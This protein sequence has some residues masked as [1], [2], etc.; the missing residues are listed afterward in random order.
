MVSDPSASAVLG[1]DPADGENANDRHNWDD[2][3]DFNGHSNTNNF[4]DQ[5]N[6]GF[7][8]TGYGRSVQVDYIASSAN[9]ID[10]N[11]PAPAGGA[12]DTKRIIVTVTAPNGETFNL[13]AVVCNF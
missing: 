6:N 11:N 1:R 10:H 2:V 8:L 12:T 7:S 3:D 4:L 5:N 13:V 9:P